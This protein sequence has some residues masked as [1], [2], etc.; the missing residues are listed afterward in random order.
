MAKY[1]QEEME[2]TIKTLHIIY[3]TCHILKIK[4]Y[5]RASI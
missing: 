1:V 4:K 5:I 3:N 2:K